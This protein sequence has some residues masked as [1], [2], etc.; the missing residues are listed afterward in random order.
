MITEE[1]R[2]KIVVGIHGQLK[3]SW[4][5]DYDSDELLGLKLPAIIS[6]IDTSSLD[7]SSADW[8]LVLHHSDC[9][10]AHRGCQFELF[11]FD[12]LDQAVAAMVVQVNNQ[13]LGL[14]ATFMSSPDYQDL[15]PSKQHLEIEQFEELLAKEL[16]SLQGQLKE[17]GASARSLFG[18]SIPQRSKR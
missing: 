9:N 16:H 12:R 5:V 4:P 13:S 10:T 1:I 11:G 14:M 17:L 7:D 15:E 6:L 8:I 18:L 2:Q 3:A